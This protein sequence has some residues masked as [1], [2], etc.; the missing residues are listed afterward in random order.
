MDEAISLRYIIFVLSEGRKEEILQLKDKLRVP[1]LLPLRA[2]L[3]I[4]DKTR[5][6]VSVFESHLFLQP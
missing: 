5:S 3:T 1:L 6:K 4:S 2:T